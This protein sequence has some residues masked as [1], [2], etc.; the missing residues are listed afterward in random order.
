MISTKQKKMTS[1]QV[2]RLRI[3]FTTRH[4]TNQGLPL[5]AQAVNN[6]LTISFNQQTICLSSQKFK[7]AQ[8]TLWLDCKG[9]GQ[10]I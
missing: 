1:A 6:N 5:E 7:L 8:K 4:M 9:E 2:Y 10:N 3:L